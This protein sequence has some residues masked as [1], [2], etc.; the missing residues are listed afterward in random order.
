MKR[1]FVIATLLVVAFA[2]GMVAANKFGTPA[3]L[4]HIVTV[5]WKDEATPEQR[6]QA[7][8]GIR[9]MAGEVPGVRNIWLKTVKVQPNTYNAVFVMEFQNQKAFD[10]YADHPAHREWEKVYLPIRQRS[11]TH[12]V[13]N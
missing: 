8:D 13:T 3:T 1:A 5:Q 7:I 6:Q 4:L 9:K 2:A 10:A 11:T 12:D